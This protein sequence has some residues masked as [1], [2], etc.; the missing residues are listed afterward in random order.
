MLS[1]IDYQHDS[2]KT[3]YCSSQIE[4]KTFTRETKGT[5]TQPGNQAKETILTDKEEENRSCL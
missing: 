2:E 4:D 5:K 1:L 3:L